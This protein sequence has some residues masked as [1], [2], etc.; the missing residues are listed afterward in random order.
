MLRSFTIL[1]SVAAVFIFTHCKEDTIEPVL[2]GSISGQVF[3]QENSLPVQNASITTSPPSS[4]ILTDVNGKFLIENCTVGNYTITVVKNGYEKGIVTISVAEERQTKA[5]IFLQKE[6][7]VLPQKPKNPIP[8]SAAVDQPVSLVLS[9]SS[10]KINKTT[11]FDVYLHKS[12]APQ[13]EPLIKDYTDTTIT[14]ENLDFK[15]TYYWQVVSRDSAGNE[16]FS[17]VWNFTTIDFPDNPIYYSS[18]I[19]NNLEIV[20]SD[21]LGNTKIQLTN[22]PNKEWWIRINKWRNKL[23]FVSDINSDNHI[24]LSDINGKNAVR[25]TTLPVTGYHNNGI[26]FCWSSNGEYLLYSHY[27]KLFR[28]RYDGTE[29]AQIAA[30]PA[31]RH[32]REC[33]WSVSGNQIAVITIGSNVFDS[34]IYLMNSD[35]SGMKLLIDNLPGCLG[36]LDFSIDGRKILFT[37]DVSGNE[38]PD[39]RQ[40]DSHIKLF[41]I[42]DSTIEDISASKNAGTNDLF[43]QFSPDGAKIIFANV[44]NDYSQLPSIWIMDFD[45]DFRKKLFDNGTMP[46]WK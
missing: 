46:D 12:N 6:T 8:N 40:L 1:L 18:N 28:I 3:D 17:E 32:F 45:G 35:G 42:E 5:V 4:A 38:S 39:G 31:G 19:N 23:A 9:W 16:V 22:S 20:S 41:G 30:A 13:T 21:S 14:V 37:H 43:P 25:I 33:A 34:E 26:G 24:F 36:G 15:T 44:P 11:K 27:D 7:G 29:L 10:D 2:I